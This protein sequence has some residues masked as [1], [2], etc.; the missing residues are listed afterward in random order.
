MRDTE[1]QEA[2]KAQRL[3]RGPISGADG[4][5]P[6][7]LPAKPD[8]LTLD[9][10]REAILPGLGPEIKRIVAEELKPLR[11]PVRTLAVPAAPKSP[12]TQAIEDRE[13]G[14]DFARFAMSIAG[15]K[16]VYNAPGDLRAAA[17]YAEERLHAPDVARALSAGILADGGALIPEDFRLEVIEFLRDEAVVRRAGASVIGSESDVVTYP[18]QTSGASAS[19]TGEL[20]NIVP[21]QLG[22]GQLKA[23]KKKLTVLTPVSNDLIR[24]ARAGGG[25]EQMV[26]NDLLGAIAQK[27]DITFIRALGDQNQPKGILNWVAAGGKFNANATITVANVRAD[28]VKAWRL[29]G[30]GMKRAPR[31]GI[32]FVTRRTLG[33]LIAAVDANSNPAFREVAEQRTI[34]GFPYFITDQ[35]PDNLGGGTD[36]SEVYFGDIA[37]GVITEMGDLAVDVS[38][39]AAYDDS[40]TLRAAFSRDETVIRMIVGHDFTLRYDRAFSVIQVVKWI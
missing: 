27:E 5:V 8:V 33:F 9:Q 19:Y 29:Q 23:T 37:E 6:P 31:R 10:V 40:G 4:V 2:L 12:R 15:A 32:W 1:L 38:G 18:K 16:L 39:E 34:L 11:E 7:V 35:I 20:Q 28:L 3:Y 36:E 13:H 17:R 14:V 30:Q 21:S 25:A 24:H 26:R 22:T